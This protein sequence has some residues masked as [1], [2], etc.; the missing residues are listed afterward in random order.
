MTSRTGGAV[1]SLISHVGGAGELAQEVG[2]TSFVIMCMFTELQRCHLASPLGKPTTRE[3]CSFDSVISVQPM[4]SW[5]PD[6]E[7]LCEQP[8][9]C[10]VGG[11][12]P[13]FK[14]LHVS[15]CLLYFI[16]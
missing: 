8:R 14:D 3:H 4:P 12:L 6:F 16:V 2:H 11:W 1:T 10:R 15:T 7:G 13:G 5:K 9:T